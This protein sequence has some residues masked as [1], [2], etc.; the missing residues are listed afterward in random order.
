MSLQ[1]FPVMRACDLVS[2]PEHNRIV[3]EVRDRKPSG[4]LR[5]SHAAR[6]RPKRRWKCAWTSVVVFPES[7]RPKRHSIELGSGSATLST[8]RS[9][10]AK[11]VPKHR[12]VDIAHDGDQ[13]WIS[14]QRLGL[15]CVARLSRNMYSIVNKQLTNSRNYLIMVG[16]VR[17]AP[18]RGGAQTLLQA[19]VTGQH[20]SSLLDPAV[21]IAVWRAGS[22]PARRVHPNQKSARQCE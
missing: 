16:G 10:Q 18:A 9:R 8:N 2:F 1:S 11:H 7:N 12:S 22:C 19:A 20:P 17:P 4:L 3:R 6:G 21:S 5:S 13:A 15:C 14:L